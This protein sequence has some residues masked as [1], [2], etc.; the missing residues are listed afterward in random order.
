VRLDTLALCALCAVLAP[1][2]DA[3]QPAERSNG[4]V[5]TPA[6][7][8]SFTNE[9][10]VV[11]AVLNALDAG[12]HF[13]AYVVQWHGRR[14]LVADDLAISSRTVGERVSFIATR[15]EVN[16]QCVLHFISTDRGIDRRNTV[17][18]KDLP[19]WSADSN[20]GTIEEVLSA[21]QAGCRFVAYILTWHHARIAVSD[22][23]SSSRHGPGERLSFLA[24]RIAGRYGP[25]LSFSIA[26]NDGNAPER[27]HTPAGS[28]STLENGIVDEVLTA[29]IDGYTYRAYVV[30]WGGAR[31]VVTDPQNA[32]SYQLG[33]GV[34][35]QLRR[36]PGLLPGL[37]GA[38]L[39]QFNLSVP[40][41]RSGNAMPAHLSTSTDTAIVEEVLH[42]EL[43]GYRSLVYVARW[44][45]TRIAVID[46]LANTRFGTGAR[47]EIPVSRDEASGLRRLSFVLLNF[48]GNAALPSTCAPGGAACNPRSAAA[49]PSRL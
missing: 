45:G 1:R 19:S 40:Q 22:P 23:L 48:P 5:R 25:N 18:P 14:V 27:A 16:G 31:V 28:S 35:F 47:I 21:E 46:A 3:Q 30:R 4:P 7:R 20:T 44:R 6:S 13:N 9:T 36:V 37:V 34:Q 11:E 43:D 42:T 29:A 49:T 2:T 15:H 41:E 33:D 39:L 8:S 24:V 26:P 10:A 12:Y 32:A 38:G 17:P